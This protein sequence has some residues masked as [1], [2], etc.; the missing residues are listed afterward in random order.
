M[1]RTRALAS[2]LL[3]IAD[4]L[5]ARGVDLSVGVLRQAARQLAAC[6][7]HGEGSR[8]QGCGRPIVQPLG[9]GRPRRWCGRGRCELGISGRNVERVRSDESGADARSGP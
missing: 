1:N 3:A 6:T 9:R 5:E 8:C 7:C 2:M 4:S